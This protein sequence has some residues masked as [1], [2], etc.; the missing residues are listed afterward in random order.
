V[1]VSTAD[2]VSRAR[3]HDWYHTLELR[4]G[5]WT[6]GWF[7]LRDA[8]RH[9][10]LPN[11]MSGMRVLEVG[12][13]D[14]FWAFEMER[15]GADVTAIDLDDERDLDWP[16][17]Q[18][19][20]EFPERPRGAG[21]QLAKEIKGSN[22]ERIELSVYDA[23]P[24][25]LGTFDLV[26]CGSVLIHLRDALLALERIN[27]L[28]RDRFISC[29]VF[30]PVLSLVPLSAGRFKAHRP[31]FEFWRPNLK[32]WRKMMWAA[33]FARV[34]RRAIFRMKAKDMKVPHVVHHAFPQASAV[35]V[36]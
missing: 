33:G 16:P 31:A 1:E 7:D 26:F 13:W 24:E 10:D 19:P 25:E 36:P 27:G 29:E 3:E 5:E 22:V 15:R 4:P 17:R 8:V 28:T 2:P 20:A 34:E 35:D 32:G 14:G 12:T 18:R 11:D 6:E 21:F 30:D 9:Y 23:T